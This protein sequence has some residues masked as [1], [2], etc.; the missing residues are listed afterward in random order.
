M[1]DLTAD[2][3]L[4]FKGRLVTEKFIMDTSSAQSSFKGVPMMID[5]SVDNVNVVTAAGVTAVD[6]DVFM[7]I[8]MEEVAVAA[9]AAEK[10]RVE[11]AVEPS[12]I[13]FKSTALTM[14]DAGKP[15]YMSDTS[16]LTTSNGAYPRIGKLYTIEDGII[17]IALESPK[18]LD[19][20]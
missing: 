20:P 18:V 19:V 14:A 10:T 4:R 7:G 5:A 1:A 11:C 13:G 15:V 3:Y 6:G 9:S 12:I 8:S 16:T 2:A 17:Y